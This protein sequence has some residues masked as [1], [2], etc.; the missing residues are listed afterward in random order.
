MGQVGYDEPF[1]INDGKTILHH[2]ASQSEVE[3]K[4]EAVMAAWQDLFDSDSLRRPASWIDLPI[5]AATTAGFPHGWTALDLLVNNKARVRPR[6]VEMLLESRAD[7]TR[8]RP[9]GSG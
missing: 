5:E 1:H 6:M 9:G 3:S 8:R 4:G 7:M 2:L